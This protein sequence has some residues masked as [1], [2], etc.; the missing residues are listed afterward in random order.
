[1]ANSGSVHEGPD[2]SYTASVAVGQYV[3]V[4]LGA[5]KGEIDLA[6]ANT[7]ESIGITQNSA[8]IGESVTVRTRGRSL[9]VTVTSNTTI[10][11]KLTGSTAGAGAVTTTAGH[12]VVAIAQEVVVA[13]LKAEVEIVPGAL[14]YD[15]F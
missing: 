4:K 10:G 7:D 12:K 5:V 13:G 8:G 9:M 2:E 3:A 15:S 6:D 11:A 14:R 1:M